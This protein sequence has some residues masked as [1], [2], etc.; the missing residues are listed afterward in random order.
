MQDVKRRLLLGRELRG[1]WIV[2]L[3]HPPPAAVRSGGRLAQRLLVEAARRI[4]YYS[5]KSKK[6]DDKI[7]CRVGELARVVISGLTF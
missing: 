2:F 7:T 3:S 6:C 5:D 4:S 1:S